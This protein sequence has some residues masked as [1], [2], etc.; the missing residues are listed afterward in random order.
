MNH[1]AER[2]AESGCHGIK[3]LSEK[4]LPNHPNRWSFLRFQANLVQCPVP[5][6]E[7]ILHGL[8]CPADRE[9]SDHS[10]QR[11]NRRLQTAHL[12]EDSKCPADQ[13]SESM[14]LCE[15]KNQG[16]IGALG[17]AIPPGRDV[18]QTFEKAPVIVEVVKK[19]N[20]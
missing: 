15:R 20:E 7:A 13:P 3:Q 12:P 1:R 2:C 11:H 9:R 6:L 16:P 17:V 10:L 14:V 5:R 18:T 19:L 8:G 4:K